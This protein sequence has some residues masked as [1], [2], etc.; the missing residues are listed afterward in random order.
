M[1]YILRH[2]SYDH[3][4]HASAFHV[5]SDSFDWHCARINASVL[6]GDR[7]SG[8][9]FPRRE[10][11]EDCAMGTASF[12][13]VWKVKDVGVLSRRIRLWQPW[14]PASRSRCTF[15]TH[16]RAGSDPRWH[17]AP[18]NTQTQAHYVT[19]QYHVWS[20]SVGNS[21]TRQLPRKLA[22]CWQWP[23]SYIRN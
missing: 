14:P 15:T 5:A 12:V 7:N 10:I 17:T 8:L 20:L 1:K 21:L 19:N 18:Y 22:S 13:G 23:R 4:T 9:L 2:N 3:I 11:G 6:S 16:G